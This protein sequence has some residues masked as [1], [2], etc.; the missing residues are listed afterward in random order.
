[1]LVVVER[2]NEVQDLRLLETRTRYVC[3]LNVLHG[4]V[5]H[6][7]EASSVGLSK[8]RRALDIL[9]EPA[10]EGLVGLGLVDV[11]KAEAVE[12]ESCKHC[13]V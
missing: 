5:H 9:G 3:L 13:C 2:N 10:E 7:A 12:S 8:R 1:M 6:H 11:V 4:I